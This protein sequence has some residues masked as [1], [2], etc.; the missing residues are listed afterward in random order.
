VIQEHLIKKKYQKGL[1]CSLIL[2]K[3]CTLCRRPA[4]SAYLNFPVALRYALVETMAF[5]DLPPQA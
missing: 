4:V 1:T 3:Y 5:P 2:L